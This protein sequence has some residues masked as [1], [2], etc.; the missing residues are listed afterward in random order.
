MWLQEGASLAQAFTLFR[1]VRT[2][3]FESSPL[4]IASEW[5]GAGLLG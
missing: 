4:S 3:V 1:Q 2:L 5:R